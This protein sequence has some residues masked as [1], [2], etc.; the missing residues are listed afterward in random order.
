VGEAFAH[1]SNE[2]G[3]KDALQ[4]C[5]RLRSAQ[6]NS[7]TGEAPDPGWCALQNKRSDSL[8]QHS[9]ANGASVIAPHATNA[10]TQALRIARCPAF[11]A[12][13]F[14]RQSSAVPVRA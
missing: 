9:C 4:T 12:I 3:T 13:A 5:L 2:W 10:G 6:L 7:S 1:I 11:V 8:A 14:N